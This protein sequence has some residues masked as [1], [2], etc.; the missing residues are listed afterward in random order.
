MCVCG[1]SVFL[2]L[3]KKKKRERKQRE[4][5]LNNNTANT[6]RERGVRQEERINL[7]TIFGGWSRG[8]PLQRR[9]REAGKG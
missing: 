2:I 8:C 4:I 9:G 1:D 5:L 3:E 7:T 6:G